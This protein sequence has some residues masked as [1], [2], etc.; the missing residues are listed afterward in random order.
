MILDKTIASKVFSLFLDV[1]LNLI[2]LVEKMAPQLQEVAEQGLKSVRFVSV[3]AL[4]QEMTGKSAS[5]DISPG[6]KLDRTVRTSLKVMLGMTGVAFGLTL[7]IP[8]HLEALSYRSMTDTESTKM[9]AFRLTKD[10]EKVVHGHDVVLADF[11]NKQACEKVL[12]E[13]LSPEESDNPMAKW[14]LK[15]KRSDP[16]HGSVKIACV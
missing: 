4:A 6:S 1:S 13:Y 5:L 11:P 15:V 10:R 3:K 7:P 9:V 16:T 8:D 14:G 12:K 2:I